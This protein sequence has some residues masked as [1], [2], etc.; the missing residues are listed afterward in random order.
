MIKG[1]R[2]NNGFDI[3][4]NGCYKRERENF[5]EEMKD[6]LEEVEMHSHVYR[7]RLQDIDRENLQIKVRASRDRQSLVSHW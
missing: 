6:E 2:L 4:K 7:R 5:N 1:T 3:F